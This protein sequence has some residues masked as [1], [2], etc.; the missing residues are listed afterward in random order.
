MSSSTS[1]AF[2]GAIVAAPWLILIIAVLTLIAT[3]NAALPLTYLWQWFI[4]GPFNVRVL[5]VPEAAGVL[6]LLSVLKGVRPTPPG[7][8]VKEISTDLVM[9]FTLPWAAL[10]LG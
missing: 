9:A 4:A 10:L 1:S 7:R 2:V 8:G 5:S 6:T 3:F